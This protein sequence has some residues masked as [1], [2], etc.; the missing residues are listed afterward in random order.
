LGRCREVRIPTLAVLLLMLFER[1]VGAEE[2]DG[3]ETQA[4][5]LFDQGV[6]ARQA[7]D[8]VRSTEVFARSYDLS[9]QPGTL[10]NLALDEES[11]GRRPAAYRR[12]RELLDRFGT[13]ISGRTRDHVRQRVQELEAA[14]ASVE[15]SCASPGAR[16]TVDDESA[17]TAP[18]GEALVIEPGTHEIEAA[19]DPFQPALARVDLR[20]GENPP[21]CLE[22]RA[23]DPPGEVGVE[24]DESS[25]IEPDDEHTGQP[26]PEQALD[27]SAT[28]DRSRRGFWRGPWP[29]AIGTILLVAA[30][31]ITT[32][33]LWPEEQ[34]EPDGHLRMR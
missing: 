5:E 30:G 7:G 13:V 31:A 29:W 9:P 4:R 23:P 28:G 27:R 10:L 3:D 17:G 19:L 25:P 18:L 12:Y 26:V 34:P 32:T 15:V 8:F 33:V 20:P 24:V 16:V 11:A 2:V 14:L 6:A 1:P 22:L 21:V